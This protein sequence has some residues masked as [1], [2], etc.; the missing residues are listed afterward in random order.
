MSNPLFRHLR[1]NKRPRWRTLILCCLVI[2]ACS[3]DQAAEQTVSIDPVDSAPVAAATPSAPVDTGWEQIDT[4]MEY[5]RAT[6]SAGPVSAQVSMVRLDPAAYRVRVAYDSANPGRV[7]QWGEAVQPL[8]MINGGYFDEEKKATAL[9]IFDGIPRGTSYEGFGGMVVIN[10]NGEFE[11]RSLR[12]QPYDPQEQLQQAM[13]SAPMLIQPGGT[14]SEL[15]ADQDRSRRTV[16]A[17]DTSGRILLIVCD[18]LSFTLREMG[19]ALKESDLELDA[20]LN[21]DGGRS[22]G[23]YVRT[24]AKN[25][26]VDSFE[27]VPLVLI[28]DRKQ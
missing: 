18:S 23:L 1:F 5:R 28:V 21:L 2:S 22:S 27:T 25:L 15:D 10:A 11:L 9:V 16:V 4:A 12:Q 24:E 20:A 26:V 7:S 8:A 14:L 17:R 6:L 19:T 13:Q 3:L